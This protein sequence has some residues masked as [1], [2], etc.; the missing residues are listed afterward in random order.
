[1]PM[2]QDSPAGLRLGSECAQFGILRDDA[3]PVVHLEHPLPAPR[4]HL[5]R[6][7]PRR[8]MPLALASPTRRPRPRRLHL[9]L[10]PAP[11]TEMRHI[12]PDTPREVLVI[13]MVRVPLPPPLVAVV[14]I[15]VRPRLDGEVA[16]RTR[17]PTPLSHG[18]DAPPERDPSRQDPPRH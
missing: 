5:P 9:R 3:E 15:P 2:R 7:L 11:E 17:K 8:D 6:Q 13:G 4:A 10:T 1:M 14:R 18:L 12:V 16:G